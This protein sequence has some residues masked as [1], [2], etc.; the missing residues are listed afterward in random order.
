MTKI[1]MV[2]DQGAAVQGKE[3]TKATLYESKAFQARTT[4]N[5][6]N[7][8]GDKVGNHKG[9]VQLGQ[10]NEGGGEINE[11]LMHIQNVLPISKGLEIRPS[12]TPMNP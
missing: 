1:D 5:H 11:D 4:V 8:K 12:K 2:F 10:D 9:I 7:Y 6:P 3:H